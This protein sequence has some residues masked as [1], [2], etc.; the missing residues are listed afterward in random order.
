MP[1]ESWQGVILGPEGGTGL[2]QTLRLGGAVTAGLAVWRL[3]N[4]GRHTG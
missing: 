4:C 1:D 2:L 3:Q